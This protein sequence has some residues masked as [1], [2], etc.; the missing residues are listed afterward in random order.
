LHALRCADYPEEY[1]IG[2]ITLEL[3][4]PFSRTK[5]LLSHLNKMILITGVTRVLWQNKEI[6][7]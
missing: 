3:S 2:I 6:E 1:D 5:T 4:Q 7:K